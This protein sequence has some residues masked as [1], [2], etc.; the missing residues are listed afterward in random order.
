MSLYTTGLEDKKHTCCVENFGVLRQVEDARQRLKTLAVQDKKTRVI[1]RN[2]F[3]VY[4]RKTPDSNGNKDAN[5]FEGQA[6]SVNFG[7]GR[8]VVLTTSPSLRTATIH[9]LAASLGLLGK[10]FRKKAL[11]SAS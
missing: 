7:I 4:V 2:H 3:K 10:S 9:G 6:I 8:V 1:M 5:P 11:T